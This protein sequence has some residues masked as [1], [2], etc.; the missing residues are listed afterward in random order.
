[1]DVRRAS[2]EIR[3]LKILRVYKTIVL[4]CNFYADLRDTRR[5]IHGFTSLRAYNS[6][7]NVR[8]AIREFRNRMIFN[9]YNT[10][11][12]ISN[13]YVIAREAR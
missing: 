12:R 8:Q 11:V 1:M 2:R 6:Y 4:I 7:V 9:V 13:F 10:I 5:E 3:I